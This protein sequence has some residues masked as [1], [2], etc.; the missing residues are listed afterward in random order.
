MKAVILAGGLGTRL[1]EETA[2]LPKPLV[3]IGNEPI[4]WHIMKIF[5]RHGVKEFIICCGYKSYLIKRYFHDYRLRH[6]SV[7]Y[8]FANSS[9]EFI[10]DALDDWRVT[11][12]ETGLNTMTGG[13]LKRTRNLLGP[14]PFFMTYGDGVG[15]IDITRLLAFHRSHGKRA[16]VTAVQPTGRFGAMFL[17]E[18]D[19]TVYSFNEKP[20]G[21]GT[22]IN[23]G[24][25]VLDPS[26]IDLIDDDSTTWEHGPMRQLTEAREL[27]AYRH[28]GFWHPMDTLRDK[29]V[30]NELWNSGRAPWRS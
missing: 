5:A 29:T 30:L 20:R 23:G 26:V 17:T 27:V 10:D 18:E 21:D 24:F 8:D 6:S 2:I 28:H 7:T 25:F 16:T 13:R 11:L 9:T 22:W 3:E 14:G 1:S 4:L 12:L 15:D 19:P